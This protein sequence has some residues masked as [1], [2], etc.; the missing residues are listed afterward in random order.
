MAR[1][2]RGT[3]TSAYAHG[4]RLSI[5]K[6]GQGPSCGSTEGQVPA[7]P[8]RP[9]R[10]EPSPPDSAAPWLPARHSS[11]A[12]AGR[13][14]GA[15]GRASGAPVCGASRSAW[16][17]WDLG[18]G[19]LVVRVQASQAWAHVP[20]PH[21]RLGG[22]EQRVPPPCP[23]SETSGVAAATDQ[24][25]VPSQAQGRALACSGSSRAHVTLRGCTLL[26]PILQAGRLRPR[27]VK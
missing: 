13:A 22:L 21:H 8:A 16:S 14:Q 19:C 1:G 15:V 26:T 18:L 24:V 27:V 3:R 2:H 11:Q 17:G 20:P 5:K 23:R 9:E 10:P 7:V 25:P 6:R 4:H 12:A